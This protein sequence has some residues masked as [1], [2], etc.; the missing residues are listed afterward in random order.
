[1][2][3]NTVEEIQSQDVIPA[4]LLLHLGREWELKMRFGIARSKLVRPRVLLTIS[5]S[6]WM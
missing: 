6:A 1:M 2:T 3:I 4:L 5:D